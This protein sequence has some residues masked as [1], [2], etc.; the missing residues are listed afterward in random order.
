M[1]ELLDF[2]S[3]L[4]RD[5]SP[6][7]VG[8]IFILYGIQSVRGG[9]YIQKVDKFGGFFHRNLI[10]GVFRSTSTRLP[11]QFPKYQ[12]VEGE[13]AQK[14]G[15]SKVRWGIVWICFGIILSTLSYLYI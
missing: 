10:G 13:Q 3:F 8:V 7:I 14:Y 11:S 12:K 4:V 2:I 5:K 9:L 15:K 6:F 1:E